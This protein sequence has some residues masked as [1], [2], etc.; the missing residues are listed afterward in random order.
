[1]TNAPLQHG[2]SINFGGIHGDFGA[3]V[4]FNA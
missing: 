3:Y 2:E 1:M 4:L